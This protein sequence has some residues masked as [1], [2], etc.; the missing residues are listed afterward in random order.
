[1]DGEAIGIEFETKWSPMDYW[2]LTAGYTLLRLFLHPDRDSLS[3]KL[4]PVDGESPQHQF[5]LRSALDLP[6]G[7]QF[8]AAL[9][10]V[11]KLAD[12]HVPAYTR[13][14]FRLGYHPVKALELSLALQNLIG[15]AHREFSGNF[16]TTPTKIERSI[17]GKLTWRF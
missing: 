15:P 8:D 16:L 5:Q 2:R 10:R 17:Y 6:H 14:D 13:V 7:F 9:Y 1:M 12:V 11:G 3:A 4:S